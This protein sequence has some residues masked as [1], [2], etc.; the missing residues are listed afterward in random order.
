MGREGYR[1]E[2]MA[3]EGEGQLRAQVTLRPIGTP[4]PLGFTGLAVATSVLACAN[5]AWLAKASQHQVALVLLLFAV[6]LQTL[7]ALLCFAGRD[8]PT[9]TG[10]A[11]QGASWAVIGLV[12]LGSVPGSRSSTLG[13]FLLAA[14]ASLIPSVFTA[15]LAKVVPAAVMGTTALRFLLTGLYELLGGADLERAAGGVGLFLAVLALYTA[16]A[17]DL[18]TVWHR[19]VLP[20]GRRGQAGPE[21]HRQD[22]RQVEHEP[23]VRERL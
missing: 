1:T 22:L 20:L 9:G 4:L 12:L 17:V 3:V 6:P 11:V 14:S 23:G 10:F 13:A 15:G 16:L 18:E 19:T 5:L 21:G 8:S 7:A 2:D